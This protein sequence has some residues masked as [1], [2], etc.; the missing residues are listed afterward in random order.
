LISST[1]HAEPLDPLKEYRYCGTPTRNSDGQILRSS[2]VLRAFQRNHPCPS[3]G[4][5]TGSCPGWAKDHIIPL[6]CGGCDSVTNLQWLPTA[7]KTGTGWDKDR[8]ER[9]VYD[10]VDNIP[11]TDSCTNVILPL[12]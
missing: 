8:W 10:H 2:S 6:A 1:G 4:L 9:K 7:I 11:D 3:T 12:E 5:T